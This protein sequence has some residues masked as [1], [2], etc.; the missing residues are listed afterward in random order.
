[1]L[2]RDRSNIVKDYILCTSFLLLF[3]HFF[4]WF[5]GNHSRPCV[6]S[7]RSIMVHHGF[8]S[9]DLRHA[10]KQSI[11]YA[12]QNHTSHCW[13]PAKVMYPTNSTKLLFWL[14][15]STPIFIAEQCSNIHIYNNYNE[16][17]KNNNIHI[18]TKH[19]MMKK[20]LPLIKNTIR[21]PGFKNNNLYQLANITGLTNL[22]TNQ[23][24][25]MVI[26]PIQCWSNPIP[27]WANPLHGET[28]PPNGDPILPNGESTHPM[29]SQPTPWWANPPHGEPI[30]PHGE[31]THPMMRQHH[32][33]VRQHHPKVIQSH[34]MAS[35]PHPLVS[36]PNPHSKPTKL[37]AESVSPNAELT[38]TQSTEAGKIKDHHWM[39]LTSVSDIMQRRTSS[40]WPSVGKNDGRKFL[41]IKPIKGTFRD[42]CTIR[43]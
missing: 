27:W 1:M 26:Q 22:I 5:R 30:S 19:T 33:M 28:T 7:P 14:T 13:L 10:R 43:N 9:K 41:K 8:R 25:P 40:Y 20:S 3:L 17:S 32:P 39:S 11:Y 35:Q 16:Y 29:V 23:P 4:W 31:P 42:T 21:H 24:H 2:S 6:V 37:H 34:P 12:K 18:C 36:Q 38:P 15:R